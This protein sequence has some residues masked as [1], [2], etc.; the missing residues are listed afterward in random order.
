[1]RIAVIG[2]S[3]FVGRFLVRF[4]AD[5]GADVTVIAR[6][7]LR[8]DSIGLMLVGHDALVNCAGTKS[9]GGENAY[10]ANVRL[11]LRLLQGVIE[12]GV[13]AMIHISSVAALTSSTKGIEP[14]TDTYEGRPVSDYGQSKR[15][16]DDALQESA[17]KS[18]FEGLVLLRPPILIGAEAGGVYAMIRSMAKAGVPLPLA[19]THNRRSYMHVHNLAAAIHAA[20]GCGLS[21]SFIVT[22]SEP[23]STEELYRRMVTAAGHRG[24]LFSIGSAGRG[25]LRRL[26]GNRGDS[27]FG[28]A[29]FSGA[30]FEEQSRVV[31]PI[32]PNK[33]IEATI[34]DC[35]AQ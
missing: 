25:I 27:L 30:R 8:N 1:M 33:T 7:E 11:P 2:A 22:D 31:W 18:S 34:T 15:A 4:L 23:I 13:P 29:A 6:P 5:A 3:G 12:A 32:A 20:I 19:G 10:E 28:D 16:G 14:V 21:G 9:G 26:L 35:T 24:R 17:S